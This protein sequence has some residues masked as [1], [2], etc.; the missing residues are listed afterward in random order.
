MRRRYSRLAFSGM[1]DILPV[2]GE[3]SQGTGLPANPMAITQDFVVRGGR[4]EGKSQ[5]TKRDMISM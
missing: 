1:T 2:C 5:R 4:E 3:G